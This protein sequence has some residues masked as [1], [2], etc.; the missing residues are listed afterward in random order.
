MQHY[1]SH[2][3]PLATVR[4]ETKS[5]VG[6]GFF[7]NFANEDSKTR[8]FGIVTNKHV[9]S[10]EP[11]VRFQIASCNKENNSRDCVN[12]ITFDIHT[13]NFMLHPEEDID[14]AVL[15]FGPIIRE[16]NSRGVAPYF[17]SY[18][19]NSIPPVEYHGHFI[20]GSDIYMVGYPDGLWDEKNLL[21]L[22]RKGI[23]A[24]SMDVDFQGKPDFAIDCAVF[25]GSSGSP[26]FCERPALDDGSPHASFLI[27]ILH[28]GV[29]VEHD[30]VAIVTPIDEVFATIRAHMHL[31]YCVKSTKLTYFR[32]KFYE[33][34]KLEEARR[35][36]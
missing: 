20:V 5:S 24:T 13:E 32:E 11:E 10:G 33:L 2:L 19:W 23:L 29:L 28:S 27:G 16:L 17:V 1:Q 14:L 30:G 7:F 9:I 12:K 25:G 4:I 15:P 34:L 35:I 21:P 26:I 31:G 36:E 22:M 18:S 3:L 6:T 8:L